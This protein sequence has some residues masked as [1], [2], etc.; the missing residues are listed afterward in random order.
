MKARV[1]PRLEAKETITK[2]QPRPNSAPAAS[3][4]M[5][6]PGSDSAVTSR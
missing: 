5:A 6:A 3:V 1:A 2:P 4:M